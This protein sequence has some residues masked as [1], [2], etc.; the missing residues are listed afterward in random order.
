MNKRMKFLTVSGILSA[1][2]LSPLGC[3]D[4][5]QDS[6]AEGSP[7]EA[8]RYDVPI[9]LADADQVC[10][11]D[12]GHC[13]DGEEMLAVLDG[14]V[15]RHL[16]GYPGGATEIERHFQEELA[17]RGVDDE[18]M[19]RLAETLADET[20]FGAGVRSGRDASAPV[21]T[22][23]IEQRV[24][25]DT[26]A[27]LSRVKPAVDDVTPRAAYKYQLSVRAIQT[28]RC[29]DDV[30]VESGCD[31]EE[32]SIYHAAWGPNWHSIK[33]TDTGAVKNP[34]D[35]WW[36]K[37]GTHI[38]PSV[39]WSYDPMMHIWRVVENDPESGS[40]SWANA[41]MAAANAAAKGY[42]G[43]WMGVAEAGIKLVAELSK[44]GHNGDDLY[45]M[46]FAIYDDP[47]LQSITSSD[48]VQPD[49]K[50]FFSLPAKSFFKNL[51]VY[52]TYV[53]G[54]WNVLTMITRSSV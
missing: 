27:V 18:T 34:G 5:H 1:L 25:A 21:T 33:V 7:A 28:K 20:E 29:A 11:G 44:L 14:L 10:L 47:T 46:F 38:V 42:G 8:R 4:D 40:F 3:G 12:D 30:G 15:A 50:M 51:A 54:G 6:Q 22:A 23:W 24:G 45:P 36:F 41:A 35:E 43:D 26:R 16:A 32:P 37:T 19:W 48:K 39:P 9:P 2:A 13:A 52:K 53:P 49:P 31:I 17:S